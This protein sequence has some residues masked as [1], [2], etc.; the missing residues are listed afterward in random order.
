MNATPCP[1]GA[2]RPYDDCCGRYHRGDAHAPTA[3]ALMRSRYSAF[4]VGDVDYLRDTWHPSTCPAHLAPD[5]DRH[6]TRLDVRSTTAGGV[7]D[8][9]GTVTFEAHYEVDGRPG[10]QREE[11]AFVRENRT[12][13]YVGEAAAR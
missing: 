12:W 3:E 5:T 13:Y 8:A 10:V 11:S 2:G 4:A 1:C 7:F 6:W 9:E